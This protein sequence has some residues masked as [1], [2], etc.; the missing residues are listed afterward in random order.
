[1]AAVPSLGLGVAYRSRERALT[2]PPSSLEQR[3]GSRANARSR[4]RGTGRGASSGAIRPPGLGWPEDVLQCQ[5][6]AAEGTAFAHAA[7]MHVAKLVPAGLR[8]SQAGSER[9]S[10]VGGGLAAPSTRRRGG[11][12]RGRFLCAP[13]S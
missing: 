5:L 8:A 11:A 7:C 2:S 9:A 12:I 13:T 6:C 4:W 1:M 10:G 3:D